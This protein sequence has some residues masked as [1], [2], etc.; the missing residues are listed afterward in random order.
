MSFWANV[1]GVAPVT[2]QRQEVFG[3]PLPTAPVYQPPAQG[4]SPLQPT[5]DEIEARHRQKAPSSRSTLTCPN[6]ASGNVCKPVGNA[7]PQCYNCGWNPRF[8]QTTG[9]IPTPGEPTHAARQ[10]STSNNYHPDQ[11]VAT[12]TG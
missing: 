1:T 7:M 11:I 10:I 12:V 4:F 2:P 6:C 8:E 5:V 9:G 3:Y